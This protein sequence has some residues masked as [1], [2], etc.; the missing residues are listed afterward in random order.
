MIADSLA[1]MPKLLVA[2]TRQNKRRV[3]CRI[4]LRLFQLF[5]GKGMECQTLGEF[6]R[7]LGLTFEQMMEL[8]EK[9]VKKPAYSV[10]EINA[11]LGEGHS[12]EELVK[13]IS[14][15]AKVL[16]MNS[17]YFVYEY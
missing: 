3:E 13:D 12:L 8:L 7:K 15:C 14:E 11:A 16:A 2:G 10:T 6:Q 17:E 4:G 5:T 1:P 9:H